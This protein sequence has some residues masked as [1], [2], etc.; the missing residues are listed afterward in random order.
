VIASGG[1]VV[2]PPAKNTQDSGE[3]RGLL[4]REHVLKVRLSQAELARLEELA[5]GWG[6]ST[7]AGML[8]ALLRGAGR[9]EDPC[10]LA[11]TS[12]CCLGR[13]RKA[14]RLRGPRA[15]SCIGVLQI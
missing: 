1:V 10:C 12:T 5:G 15:C 3:N 2:Y 14:P 11:T 7:K 9:P 6:I 13:S 4:V 8:R